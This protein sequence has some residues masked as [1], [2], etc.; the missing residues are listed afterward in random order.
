MFQVTSAD[1][2]SGKCNFFHCDIE[3]RTDPKS[4]LLETD[5]SGV[6]FV[7]IVPLWWSLLTISNTGTPDLRQPF[8]NTIIQS[9]THKPLAWSQIFYCG[10]Y[11]LIGTLTSDCRLK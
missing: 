11:S 3:G 4:S 7:I 1:L 8:F 2:Q 5:M 9:L 6:P 10:L